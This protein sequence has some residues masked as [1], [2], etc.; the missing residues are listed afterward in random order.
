MMRAVRLLKTW[1]LLK[2]CLVNKELEISLSSLALIFRFGFFV[3]LPFSH[4]L[5]RRAFW[6]CSEMGCNVGYD[7]LLGIS[8]NA[9]LTNGD[10]GLAVIVIGW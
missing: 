9:S 6:I 5:R 10:I 4:S 2:G 1:H 3:F 8:Y 7:L